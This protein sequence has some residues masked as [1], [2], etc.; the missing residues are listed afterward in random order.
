[1][2][3]PRQRA[4]NRGKQDVNMVVVAEQGVTIVSDSGSAA[5]CGGVRGC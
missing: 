3:G 1:M 2:V 4:K 5:L